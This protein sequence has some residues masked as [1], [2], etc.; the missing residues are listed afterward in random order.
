MM[1]YMWLP[2]NKRVVDTDILCI[3]MYMVSQEPPKRYDTWLTVRKLIPMCWDEI[4][5]SHKNSYKE[6]NNG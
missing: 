3:I 5:H 2:T 6:A 1:N 4:L